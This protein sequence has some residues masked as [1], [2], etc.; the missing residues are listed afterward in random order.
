[1][2]LICKRWI[3]ALSTVVGA[4]VL[5]GCSSSQ[6]PTGTVSGTVSLE[7]APVAAGE[8]SFVSSDG[9][10]ASGPISAGNFTLEDPLPVGKYSVG[11]MP[12]ELTEA[13][14]EGGDEIEAPT[15]SV[16]AGYDMP[17]TSGISHDV[18]EGAN[19]V[20]IELKAS[21]PPRGNSASDA[22]P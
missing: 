20:T 19:T 5:V 14:G 13:P 8:I 22:A 7:G 9:F 16:P 4:F 1:M 10:S 2:T 17:G 3:F 21:G 11:I 18:Q 6:G 15:S 12:P